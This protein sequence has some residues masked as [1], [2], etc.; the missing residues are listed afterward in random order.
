MKK[1]ISSPDAATGKT[2]AIE[3]KL[4][5]IMQPDMTPN[6][7]EMKTSGIITFLNSSIYVQDLCETQ[8]SPLFE[9]GIKMIANKVTPKRSN[10][11]LRL[12]QNFSPNS[13]DT[14]EEIMR[15]SQRVVPLIAFVCDIAC[16]T[17]KKLAHP[18]AYDKDFKKY[19]A[20]L[21]DIYHLDCAFEQSLKI[22][23]DKIAIPEYLVYQ[24]INSE[25][26]KIS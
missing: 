21:F 20:N 22:G 25:I 18:Q 26:K 12:L 9:K 2:T 19:V 13:S 17:N 1:I 11:I 15:K 6:G 8:N 7:I 3:T 23:S 5:R 4:M 14:H 16:H 24:F 10:Y